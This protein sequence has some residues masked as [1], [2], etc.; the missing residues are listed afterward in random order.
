M[1]GQNGIGDVADVFAAIGK[2]L[3]SFVF[4]IASDNVQNYLL[5]KLE[6]ITL[7]NGR[8]KSAFH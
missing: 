4:N 3:E 2:I 7:W 1:G 6:Q 5:G 8:M